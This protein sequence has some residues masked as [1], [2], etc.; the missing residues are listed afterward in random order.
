MPSLIVVV[1]FWPFA[2]Q[3]VPLN[4]TDSSITYRNLPRLTLAPSVMS[5]LDISR[6]AQVS[7]TASPTI[8]AAMSIP[9][10]PSQFASVPA[11]SVQNARALVAKAHES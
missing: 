3:A 8:R 2:T 6:S 1:L 9:A 4:H 5:S 11:D 10:I 7:K